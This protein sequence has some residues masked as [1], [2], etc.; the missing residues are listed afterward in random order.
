M[1]SGFTTFT[2]GNVLT[3]SEMNN[4][5]ME[6]SV[7]VFATTAARDSAITA[8]EDGMICYVTGDDAHYVY[9]TVSATSAWRRLMPPI[10]HTSASGLLTP[11]TART[12]TS[13]S[14]VNFPTTDILKIDSFVKHRS[15]S[16][17]LISING[18]IFTSISTTCTFG[19]L[20]NSIDYDVGLISVTATS[21]QTPYSVSN[22]VNVPTAGTYTIQARLK[23]AG[24]TWTANEFS[25]H[26]L[27]ATEV[28]T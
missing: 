11:T 14:Y 27:V 7:M 10:P 22:L 19:V 2:A 28:R 21:S 9:E 6:Q 26:S 8:P 4:Y 16:Q 23:V 17:L 1:G 25:K 24:G 12:T 13:T 5:L 15:D 18:S 3:A 20:V